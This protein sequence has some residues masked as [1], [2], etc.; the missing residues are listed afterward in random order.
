MLSPGERQAL[1]DLARRAIEARVAHAEVPAPGA[2]PEAL[3]A[4][5]AAF[6]SV[7]VQGQL[8]GCLG[9]IEPR[10]PSLAAT[11]ASMA[12]AAASHDPRFPPLGREELTGTTVEISVL[13]PL[14]RVSVP[15][16]ILIGRDGL[17]VERDGFRGLL[18]P[19]VA[20]EWGWTV[21]TF[22][23]ETSRKA[24][25]PRTAWREGALVWRFQAEVFSDG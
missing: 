9:C 10:G 16:E 7:H 14:E 8:R 5:G 24:G 22:L 20:T 23:E 18:L 19:Q 12:A 6:V 2:L 13:G 1:L 11:V 4:P 15:G 21:Q 3:A 17:V 25:L